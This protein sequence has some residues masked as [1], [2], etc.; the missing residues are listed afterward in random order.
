MCVDCRSWG[1]ILMICPHPHAGFG[2][3]GG[4]GATSAGAGGGNGAS[5]IPVDQE[6]DND[7]KVDADDFIIQAN[8]S[9]RQGAARGKPS[10]EADVAASASGTVPKRPHQTCTLRS[11]KSSLK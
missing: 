2:G 10:L 4:S 1:K 9:A 11:G 3:V 8:P 6:V 5:T 7:S